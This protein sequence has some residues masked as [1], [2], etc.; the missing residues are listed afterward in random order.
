[1]SDLFIGILSGTSMDA[2]D[3][4]V[5]DFASTPFKLLATHHEPF[6]L[7]LKKSL[8]K[9]CQPGHDEINQLGQL[10][11]ELGL[12]FAKTCQQ[13]LEKCGLPASAIRAVGSHGQTIRHQPYFKSPFSLQIADP[14]VIATETE[15]TTIADFRRRDIAN[16]GQGA[17]LTPAFHHYALHTPK[18]N[19]FVINIGGIANIT[20]LPANSDLPLIGY[21]SGPG[22]TL[23]DSWAQ[24]VLQKPFDDAGQW[25]ASGHIN[26]ELLNQLLADPYFKLMP[27]KSTGR[28]YFNLD[29]LK[30]KIR[31][32][33]TAHDIQATLT[34][35]TAI[36]I[37]Q[38]IKQHGFTQGDML[39]CG[40]GIQN[41]FLLGRLEQQRSQYGLYSTQNFG[42][43]P[44]WMEAIAFAWFA[45]QTLEGKPSNVPSVTGARRAVI[46][47]GIYS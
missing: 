18:Q 9:I 22:N 13:L 2:V 23:L 45:K 27:P 46:L 21:D 35:L 44:L 40:G 43:D 3:A 31:G 20:I 37:T 12:F 7:D 1:M 47:G 33:H 29:W 19:R 10:D 34:E 15:I 32:Q 41:K 16:G 14:N 24:E 11:T 17:P 42:V 39:I 8:L 26:S 36:S 4:V 38:S 25:G 30:T 5:V 28:E 6:H